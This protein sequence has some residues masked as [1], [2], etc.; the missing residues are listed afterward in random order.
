MKNNH[1]HLK[2]LAAISLVVVMC[3][4][5]LAV[6]APS[7]SAAEPIENSVVGERTLIEYTFDDLPVGSDLSTG[8]LHYSRAEPMN[9]D[10]TV[11]YVDG[12]KVAKIYKWA[13]SSMD[14]PYVMYLPTLYSS[15]TISFDLCYESPEHQ[16]VGYLDIKSGV[17]IPSSGF[18]A[19]VEL[20]NYATQG[21][22]MRSRILNVDA[23]LRKDTFV[24]QQGTWYTWQF[25]IHSH[26]S[27]YTMNVVERETG[28]VVHSKTYEF[29][30]PN[31][32]EG[33]ARMATFMKIFMLE[34]TKNATLLL[35]NI[36]VSVPQRV[37]DAY[38]Y[39]GSER[40]FSIIFDDAKIGVYT[41]AFP[42]M[43]QYGLVGTV[44][45][46]TSKVGTPGYMTWEQLQ[47]LAD[48]G[49]E[50]ASHSVDHPDLRAADYETRLYNLQMSK[51]YILENLTGVSVTTFVA[52]YS[53]WNNHAE[54]IA[55]EFYDIT[56]WSFVRWFIRA[57]YHSQIERYNLIDE[58]IKGFH[59]IFWGHNVT[60]GTPQSDDITL[61]FLQHMIDQTLEWGYVWGTVQ[62]VYYY[63][64]AR[65][66]F[67]PEI[68]AEDDVLTI[69]VG[70]TQVGTV[71]VTYPVL[72][73]S[74]CVV[75]CDGRVIDHATTEDS[76]I[77][78]IKSGQVYEIMTPS[79]YRQA[80]TDRAFEPLYAIIPVVLVL[81]VLGGLFTMLGRLKF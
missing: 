26:D 69:D 53:S 67:D 6:L 22:V 39:I 41:E 57:D 30:H 72:T 46:I 27:A 43:R 52:P 33:Q 16:V 14:A 11:A 32:G 61:D 37:V 28:T 80:Q 47:E 71:E 29:Y 10:A 54:H 51:V 56:P 68:S 18:L 77:F 64:Y 23:E 66:S 45:V 24:W 21:D 5:S 49:W 13:T 73:S 1:T 48:A 50:I 8:P 65:D 60:S 34:N 63:R 59:M 31:F 19:R 38:P 62:D 44:A 76:V 17:N 9:S 58:H 70:T 79:A 15:Y 20:T 12:E 75:L 42:M 40:A 2:R 3:L 78:D 74:E 35:D 55:Q 25:T 7:A 81:A 4:S 36:R